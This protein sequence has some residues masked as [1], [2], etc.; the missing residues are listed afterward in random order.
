MVAILLAL[1]SS[2]GYGGADFAGGLASRDAHVFRVVAAAAPAGLLVNLLL[3]PVLGADW[4]T[5]PLPG[6]LD[7]VSHRPQPSRSSTRPL[8]S[9]R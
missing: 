5:R 9:A 8:L 1:A 2:L 7:P 6:A 4:S 3:L